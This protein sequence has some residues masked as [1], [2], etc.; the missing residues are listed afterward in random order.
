MSEI[1]RLKQGETLFNKG[2]EAKD[3]FILRAG[4]LEVYGDDNNKTSDLKPI[5]MVGE[6]S[7]IDKVPR[8]YTV[9]A[10]GSCT[11]VVINKEI[12]DDVFAE[13]PEWY[14]A[15]YDSILTRVREMGIGD[16]I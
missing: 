2:D 16:F 4:I 13:M 7:F 11:L 8:K 15:M 10:Q 5:K 9:K 12:Y 3:I 6:I 1:L 14:L